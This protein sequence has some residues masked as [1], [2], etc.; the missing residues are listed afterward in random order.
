MS[1]DYE[2]VCQFVFVCKG[3]D[4]KKKGG[5]QLLKSFNKEIKTTTNAKSTVVL[6]TKCMNRCKEAPV[7]VL[8]NQWATKVKENQVKQLISDMLK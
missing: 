4:C 8:G 6:E 2:K 1:K 3:S 5:K 7:V